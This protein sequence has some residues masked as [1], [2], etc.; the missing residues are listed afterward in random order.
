MTDKNLPEIPS[1]SYPAA[2]HTPNHEFDVAMII[3]GIVFQ[4]INMD[5]NAAAQYLSNPTFVQVAPGQAKIGWTYQ[6]GT[7][8]PPS[9]LPG[10]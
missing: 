3:N 10:L 6:D 4:V 7:F 8:S 2:E 9:R 5:G 1:L